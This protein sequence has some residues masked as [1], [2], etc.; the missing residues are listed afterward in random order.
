MFEDPRVANPVGLC[1]GQ[2][3]TSNCSRLPCLF[4]HT[5]YPSPNAKD[6]GSVEWQYKCLE[7]DENTFIKEVLCCSVGYFFIMGMKAV[8]AFVGKSAVVL[9]ASDT[10]FA[11]LSHVIYIGEDDCFMFV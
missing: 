1:P 10:G 8:S 9:S 3:K 2:W 7:H 6:R 5:T 4:V 11:L